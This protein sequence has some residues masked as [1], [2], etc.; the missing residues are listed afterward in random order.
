MIE[1]L[2]RFGDMAARGSLS[3]LVEPVAA[4]WIPDL[5]VDGLEDGAAIVRAVDMPSVRLLFDIGHVWMMGHDILPALD[6]HWDIIGAIQAADMPG[7]VDVG[8]GELDWVA[9]FA[10]I[11]ARGHAA[12][13]EIEHESLDASVEGEARLVERLR[14]IGEAVSAN[15]RERGKNRCVDSWRVNNR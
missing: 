14:R 9:I 13:I 5:L 7:R 12:P 1:N 15:S 8:A 3:L 6:A 10:G 4:Q 2:K 11:A